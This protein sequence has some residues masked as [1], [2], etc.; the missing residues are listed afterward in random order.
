MII[1]FIKKYAEEL[2]KF[3]KLMNDYAHN[4][5]AHNQQ[6]EKQEESWRT[7]NIM[8]IRSLDLS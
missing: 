7:S 5:R 6:E 3:G 2:C 4:K 1:K 8:P